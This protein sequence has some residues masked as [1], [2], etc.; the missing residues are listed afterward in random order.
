MSQCINCH[1]SI[2][3]TPFDSLCSECENA[4]IKNDETEL[5]RLAEQEA[6]EIAQIEANTHTLSIGGYQLD[7]MFI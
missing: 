7:S 3:F 4:W 6:E 2:D 1:K 5:D